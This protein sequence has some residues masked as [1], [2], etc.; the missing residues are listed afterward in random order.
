MKI[1]RKLISKEPPSDVFLSSEV[2]DVILSSEV[3]T[4]TV[5]A[6]YKTCTSFLANYDFRGKPSMDIEVIIIIR[7]V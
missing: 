7:R 6:K 5:Q 2:A 1:V 3:A 4:N